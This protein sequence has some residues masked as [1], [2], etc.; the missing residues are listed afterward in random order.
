MFFLGRE[1][2]QRSP[3]DRMCTAICTLGILVAAVLSTRCEAG[4]PAP[5]PAV[6]VRVT[7][8]E[9][10]AEWR[11]GIT[12]HWAQGKQGGVFAGKTTGAKSDEAQWVGAGEASAWVD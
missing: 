5:K 7:L 3:V 8:L 6:W 12:S 2:M 4:E 11:V 10:T 1:S 9:P